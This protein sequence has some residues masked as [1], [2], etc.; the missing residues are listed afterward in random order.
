MTDD[1]ETDVLPEEQNPLAALS[2]EVER[3]LSLTPEAFA[4]LDPGALTPIV[5]TIRATFSEVSVS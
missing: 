2:A 4:V 5:A 1:C 3:L